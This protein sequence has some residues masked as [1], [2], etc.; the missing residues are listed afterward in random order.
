MARPARRPPRGGGGGALPGPGN[1][2]GAAG[3]V[4]GIVIGFPTRMAQGAA[5]AAQAARNVE[6]AVD[7]REGR[8]TASDAPRPHPRR[9]CA[10]PAP[11][12]LRP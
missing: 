1:L 4:G 5:S 6:T 2:Q 7:A 9:P 11:P 8:W 3:F 10:R 12:E